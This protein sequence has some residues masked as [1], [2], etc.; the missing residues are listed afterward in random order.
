[1]LGMLGMLAHSPEAQMPLVFW[2]FWS[3]E[4]HYT[5]LHDTYRIAIHD[6]DM[7]FCGRGLERGICERR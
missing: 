7:R 3:I 6:A 4:A 5:R 2:V 1:M